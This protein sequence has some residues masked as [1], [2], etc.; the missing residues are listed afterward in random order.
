MLST[1]TST[2]CASSG[3]KLNAK[4]VVESFDVVNTSLL[5]SAASPLGAVKNVE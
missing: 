3:V 5:M 2:F 1:N 4:F